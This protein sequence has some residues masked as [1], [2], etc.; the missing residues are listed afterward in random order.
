LPHT[1]PNRPILSTQENLTMTKAIV[2]G[3]GLVTAVAVAALTRADDRPAATTAAQP[4][5]K[6]ADEPAITE[7][8]VVLHPTQG[9]EVHGV[10]RFVQKGD[11][12]QITGEVTGL[13]PGLHGFHVH[14]YGDCTAP[15][16]TST[17]GHFNPSNMPHGGPDADH[18]H[19]G[20][21][22]NIK[23]DDTGKATINMTDK[24][25]RLNGPH[26]IIGRGMIVHAGADD[27]K[28]QPTGDAGG[29][30][31]CGVIGVANPM[32]KK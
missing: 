8:V 5:A 4:V 24:M 29:R 2:L 7:A 25:I 20:D 28:T 11:A 9:S 6:A 22:G 31:A 3:T 1:T 10:V 21:L 19:V 18:R 32:K 27:L 26:S 17:G 16:G 30:V 12:V 14:Q 23:A 15:D 13:K